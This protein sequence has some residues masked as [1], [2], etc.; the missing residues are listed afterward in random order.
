M[1]LNDYKLKFVIDADGRTARQ[2]LD[3]TYA[4]INALGGGFTQTFGGMIPLASAAAV[5]IA[6]IGLAA[7]AAGRALF[8]IT[9]TAAEYGST[10][11]DASVKTGL[12]AE[13]VSALDFAAK[14]SGT[15]LE[16]I[17]GGIAKFSKTV[18]EAA[19]GSDKAAKKLTSLGVDPQSALNDLDGAL[20][21]VFKRIGEARPGVERMTLAQKAFGKSGADLLPLM[22]QVGFNLDDF[23]KKAKELGVTIDDEAAAKADEFGDTLDQ[24]QAQLAGVGRIIGTELMPEFTRMADGMST[25]LA[26]NKGQVQSWGVTIADTMSGVVDIFTTAA[27][28]ISRFL[29]ESRAFGQS[30]FSSGGLGTFAAGGLFGL[31]IA[32]L[33]LGRQNRMSDEAKW[34]NVPIVK[35]PAGTYITPGRGGSGD[36]DKNAGGRGAKAA[37]KDLLPAF[38][39]MKS[40]VISSGNA[41]WDSW[42]AQMGSKFGVD[43]NVLLLQALG[44]S[45]FRKNAVSPKGAEGFSQF[46]PGTAARFGVNTSSIKD[47]IRGQAE[48]MGQLLSMFG[49]DYEKALAGYNAGEGKVLKYGGIPPYKETRNYV[50]KIKVGYGRRV[51]SKDA[52]QYGT[53]DFDASGDA[54]AKAAEQE[55]RDIEDAWNDHLDWERQMS[56]QRME[57]RRAEADYAVEELQQQLRQGVIDEVEYAERVGQLRVDMIQEEIDE[58]SNLIGSTENL[59]KVEKLL[60]ELATER[61]KKENDVADAIER[62]NE[63]FLKQ[64]ETLKKANQRPGTLKKRGEGGGFESR[65]DDATGKVRTM[66]DVMRQL[67][68]TATDVFMKMGEALG[69]SLESWA[70]LGSE[71]DISLKKMVAS[72]LAGVA[73]QAAT[74]AIFHVAMGV[75]AL[76]P[77]G[78]AM[79]G[80]APIHFK[81]AALWG[82]IAVGTALAGR[83]VAGDSFKS[84]KDSGSSSGAYG[85]SGG[86]QQS[87]PQPYSRASEN[88]YISGRR[89]EN[90]LVAAAIQ[91]LNAKLDSMRPGD[92][93]KVGVR[94]APGVVGQAAVN[95]FRRNPSQGNQAARTMGL[96]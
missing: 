69:A 72:T 34:A 54:A 29:Y 85:S 50:A 66:D 53:Y 35:G 82:G 80:P 15:S 27:N 19:D 94:E 75:A 65:L 58:T 95:D 4:K 37:K 96:K 78:A 84:G 90:Q 67:G 26:E 22:E 5:G 36:P 57:M 73:A 30:P 44:E 64:F 68:D 32:G 76:T 43:P 63:A 42:F 83:A 93:L 61:K 51:R 87:A 89:T 25:W 16:S 46:M 41:Q 7:A 92:V 38:G 52:G 79:Y 62:Q 23:R 74:L 45:G 86:G 13:T 56:E 3:A 39:S 8:D 14:Q 55:I 20:G 71:A 48:Y 12:A 70:L 17:T 28:A 77:W 81:A 91:K 11:Y 6:G 49:G 40:L 21:R 33:S 31:P 9:K 47:S 18:G 60:L 59:H 1:P 24:L 2:E 10:I 88:A